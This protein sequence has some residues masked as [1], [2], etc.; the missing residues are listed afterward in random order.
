MTHG[1]KAK[2]KAAKSSQASA[3]K[4]DSS[5]GESAGK[6]AGA[7]EAGKGSQQAGTQKGSLAAKK[8]AA[9]S[10]DEGAA[11]GK[12]KAAR[13]SVSKQVPEAPEGFTNPLISNAFKHAV[14]K[15]PNALR[16]LTD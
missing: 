14:K 9:P 13:Q 3:A 15:Y 6:K 4:K 7:V 16:K 1:D 5:Q 12:G 11:G 2:A 10:K 8:T